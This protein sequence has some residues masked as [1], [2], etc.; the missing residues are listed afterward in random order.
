MKPALNPWICAA[1]AAL[2]LGG[3]MTPTTNPPPSAAIQAQRAEAAQRRV[4]PPTAAD[5]CA[6]LGDVPSTLEIPFAFDQDT[7]GDDSRA[8]LDGVVRQLACH[9]RLGVVLTGEGERHQKAE[10]QHKLAQRRIAAVREYLTQK[11]VL[12]GRALVLADPAAPPPAPSA[13]SVQLQARDR[14]W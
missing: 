12:A 1:S 9:G 2:T 7:L 10:D 5:A 13:N 14:G 4:Q 8:V 11:N 3:C 6:S